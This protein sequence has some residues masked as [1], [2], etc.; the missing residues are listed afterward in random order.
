MFEAAR[1]QVRDAYA[2]RDSLLIQ[3]VSALNELNKA[4]NLMFERLREWYSIHFPE[5]NVLDSDKYCLLVEAID[6]ENVDVSKI[7]QIVGGGK[8][9]D[10]ASKVRSSMG[11]SF[12]F[13]DLAAVKCLA[14]HILELKKL[15]LELENYQAGVA[16]EVCP[17]LCHLLEPTL[18]ARIVAQ[19][20]G[21]MRLATLPASTVQV[22]G[23]EKALFKHLRSNAKPPKHG[24]IFNHPAI[25]NAPKKQRGKLARALATK[26]ST[27]A[28]ADAFSKRFIA[29]KLKAD[30][31]KRVNEIQ[32]AKSGRNSNKRF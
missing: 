16:R 27:A 2:S 1:S 28:K 13:K 32:R 25:C 15:R 10:V 8:A 7:A 29:E 11:I 20:G 30:F 24:V 21:L 12:T 4:S 22:L 23:A 5:M 31:E 3:S 18:A 19:A 9:A 17:N 6:K 26:I 14:S